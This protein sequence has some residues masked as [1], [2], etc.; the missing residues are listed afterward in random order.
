M[1]N[2]YVENLKR[3]AKGLHKSNVRNRHYDDGVLI[4][5]LYDHHHDRERLSWWD[6]CGFIMNDYKVSVAW[7]HPRTRYKEECDDLAHTIALEKFPYPVFDL[8]KQK[9][10]ILEGST[11]HFVKIGKSRKK[12]DHY[13]FDRTKSEIYLARR[14]ELEGLE[15]SLSSTSDIKVTPS[16]NSKWTNHSRF[17][18]ICVP[19]E[20][21]NENDLVQ[22]VSIVK[23]LLK[24]EKTLAELFPNYAYTKDD[25]IAEREKR[26][27]NDLHSHAVA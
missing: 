2:N 4:R 6:D 24:R 7:S 10:K 17:I 22:L 23:S 3:K 21:R 19:I 25:W 1:K 11:P 16:I 27:P 8:V 13:T 9:G 5:H 15:E 14:K 26:V 18:S 12:I 20:I